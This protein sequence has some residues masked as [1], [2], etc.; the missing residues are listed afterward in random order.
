MVVICAILKIA[1][2]FGTTGVGTLSDR[3]IM[4]SNN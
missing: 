3:Q 4:E 1:L 2:F